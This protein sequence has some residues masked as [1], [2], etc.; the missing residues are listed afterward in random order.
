MYSREDRLRGA[1]VHQ[2]RPEPAVGDQRA[3]L[4]QPRDVA[5]LAPRVPRQRRRPAREG[6]LPAVQQ[7]GQAPG[8][9]ALFRAR[10][11]HEA[12]DARAGL[13]VARGAGRVDRRG[14]ARAPQDQARARRHRRGDEARR[15]R[16][17]GVGRGNRAGDLRF[18]WRGTWH[19]LRLEAQASGTGGTHSGI[20][21]ERRGAPGRGANAIVRRE[22]HARQGRAD[23]LGAGTG[24]GERALPTSSGATSPRWRRAT[25]RS[26][27]SSNRPN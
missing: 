12:H 24:R 26:T 18:A 1:V 16:A 14:R 7:R 6:A 22:C 11:V 19:T 20:G 27:P 8:R 17:P 3:G 9:G 5:P 21:K 13:S 15:G 23:D 2:V 4:P 25:P 10:Q